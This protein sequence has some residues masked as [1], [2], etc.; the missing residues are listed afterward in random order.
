MIAFQFFSIKYLLASESTFTSLV[1]KWKM[2]YSTPFSMQKRESGGRK[3][4]R[5]E[6]R[7][8][9]KRKEGIRKYKRELQI[10]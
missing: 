8:K 6:D 5:K 3:E 2:L 1:R 4:R 10:E 9:E 7:K